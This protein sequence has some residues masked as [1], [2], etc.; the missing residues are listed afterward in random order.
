MPVELPTSRLAPSS[1]PEKAPRKITG[2][3]VLVALV[4]FFAVIFAVNMVMMT[5]ALRTMPGIEVKSAY[6]ASQRF[7]RELEAAQAQDQLGWQVDVVTAR[8]KSGV[9]GVELRDKTGAPLGGLEVF[10]RIERPTDAKLDQRIKLFV[11]GPGRYGAEFPPLATGQWLLTIE[12]RQ[13][14]ARRFLSQRKVL[15]RD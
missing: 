3:H 10:A 14:G 13:G 5:L 9:L 11:E 7:N 4:A 6:E 8:L 12:A 2:T 1:G 15:L